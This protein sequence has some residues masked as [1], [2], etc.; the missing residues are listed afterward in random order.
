M[1]GTMR[2]PL[3]LLV[4]FTAAAALAQG[5]AAD[6]PVTTKIA[7]R[8]KV[9]LGA[10]PLQVTSVRAKGDGYIF[11]YMGFRKTLGDADCAELAIEN[12]TTGWLEDG[13]TVGTTEVIEPNDTP[14]ALQRDVP[15]DKVLCVVAE[16]NATVSIGSHKLKP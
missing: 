12:G 9:F 15:P 16:H 4:L 13:G 7:A 10:G 8:K 11:L 6:K 2:I 5:P 3:T 14:R 1:E